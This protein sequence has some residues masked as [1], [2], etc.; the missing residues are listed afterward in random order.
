M[1][2][3]MIIATFIVSAII[4]SYMYRNKFTSRQM[5]SS[6]FYSINIIILLVQEALQYLC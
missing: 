2:M 6:E 4:T 3:M 1:T 5:N